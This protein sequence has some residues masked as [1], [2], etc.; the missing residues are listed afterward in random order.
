MQWIARV[1]AAIVATLA[2]ALPMTGTTAQAPSSTQANGGQVTAEVSPARQDIAGLTRLATVA[3]RCKGRSC[4]GKNPQVMG[5]GR[6]ARTIAT[7]WPAGGGPRVELRYSKRCRAAWARLSSKTPSWAFM[8]SVKSHSNY[9]A[10]G[11]Q[12]YRAYT[13]MA[14]RPL[15]FRACVKQWAS[16]SWSCTG[17]H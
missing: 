6:D 9:T 7:R 12:F 13:K 14:G 16:S 1:A 5:C 17:W 4:T 3:A 2:L 10:Y 11:S 15:R 8:L